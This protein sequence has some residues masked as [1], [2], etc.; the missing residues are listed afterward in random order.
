MWWFVGAALIA[1]MGVACGVNLG[2]RVARGGEFVW[3]PSILGWAVGFHGA[4]GVL[5]LWMVT[6]AIGQ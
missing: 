4:M 1:L 2:A 6:R 3:Q 5:A